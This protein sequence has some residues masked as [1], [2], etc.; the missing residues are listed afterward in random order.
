[1]TK[2]RLAISCRNRGWSF[3][4]L[5]A[6]LCRIYGRR[7][8]WPKSPSHRCRLFRTGRGPGPIR[9]GR[10]DLLQRAADAVQGLSHERV[11]SAVHVRLKCVGP[12]EVKLLDFA[13]RRCRLIIVGMACTRFRMRQLP[14]AERS[15]FTRRAAPRISTGTE[16]SFGRQFCE[17]PQTSPAIRRPGDALNPERSSLHTRKPPGNLRTHPLCS[18]RASDLASCNQKNI[19]SFC[20]H[21]KLHRGLYVSRISCNEFKLI[22]KKYWTR[23][24]CGRHRI[25]WRNAVR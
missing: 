6:R 13:S 10:G 15:A 1:M 12:H 24:A 11:I 16:G 25:A 18:R 19:A 7:G 21:C 20:T 5:G 14:K 4:P 3:I 2:L 17:P 8:R 9:F 23:R 22:D